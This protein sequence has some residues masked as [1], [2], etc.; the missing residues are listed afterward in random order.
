LCEECIRRWNAGD[1]LHLLFSPAFNVSPVPPAQRFD[2]LFKAARTL[3]NEKVA[4]VDQIIFT[5]GA[6]YQVDLGMAHW[7]A[8]KEAVIRKNLAEVPSRLPGSRKLRVVRAVDGI[9][10]L[11]GE[12]VFAELV[13]DLIFSGLVWDGASSSQLVSQSWKE[14]GSEPLA[15]RWKSRPPSWQSMEGQARSDRTGVLIRVYPYKQ[16]L[17]PG[18][19]ASRYREVLETRGLPHGGVSRCPRGV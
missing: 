14:D 12:T 3:R 19:V 15:S 16:S 8:A 2:E 17:E 9:L 11:E 7:K 18:E 6:A 10:L 5:L 13:R 4:D 1:Y